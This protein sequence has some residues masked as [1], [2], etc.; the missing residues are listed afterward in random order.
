MTRS[1]PAETGAL[2]CPYVPPSLH[3][4]EPHPGQ[5]QARENRTAVTTKM[6]T[7]FISAVIVGLLLAGIP[8]PLI[9]S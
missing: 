8:A 9:I 1:C 7:S 2:P 4:P 6:I 5:G 3:Y